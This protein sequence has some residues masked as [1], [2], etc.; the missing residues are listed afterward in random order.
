[1]RTTVR[2]WLPLAGAVVCLYVASMS[3]PPLVIYGLI[4]AS[5]ALCFDAATAWL[6]KAGGTGGMKDFKQ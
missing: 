4:I 6:A 3:V 5:F 1:M 2:Y